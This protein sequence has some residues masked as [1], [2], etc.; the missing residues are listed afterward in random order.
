MLSSFF[1]TSY[2]VVSI[3]LI[4]YV[5]SYLENFSFESAFLFQIVSVI[6]VSSICT[7]IFVYFFRKPL[8]PKAKNFTRVVFY[9]LT[10]GL[11]VVCGNNGQKMIFSQDLTAEFNSILGILPLIYSSIFV[12]F[13]NFIS[14]FLS[15]SLISLF[16]LAINLSA[17]ENF[18]VTI[19]E[20]LFLITM[21]CI[22]TYLFYS[23]EKHYREKFSSIM[24]FLPVE[25]ILNENS[26][27][28]DIEEISYH[29]N[30]TLSIL[31]AN[32]SKKIQNSVLETLFEKLTKVTRLL[33]HRESVYA[34]D[35]DS[36]SKSIDPDEKAYIKEICTQNTHKR[37]RKSTKVV[38]NKT[39]ELFKDFE[40]T[41]LTI[42]LKRIGKE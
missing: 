41:E 18:Q 25:G 28:T 35:L 38:I 3:Y 20:W 34:I 29:I 12:I 17:K 21:I 24:N 40:S 13:S 39:F 8:Y 23:L 33:S 4:S 32:L 2:S 30:E 1:L 11:I 26:L 37:I 19:I 15:N 6:S 14:F 31:A 16:Y 7:L 9:V 10:C 5:S 27:K 36:G 22:W 42:L